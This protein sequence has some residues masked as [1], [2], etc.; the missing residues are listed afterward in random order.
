MNLVRSFSSVGL[1]TLA[2]RIFGFVRDMLMARYIGA[3]FAS[4]AFL[5]AFRLPNMFRALFAE[6][7]FAAAFVPLFNRKVGE[8]EGKL[9]EALRFAEDALSVLLPVLLVFTTVVMIGAGPAVL[10]MSGGF[11]D[12]TPEQFDYAVE[13]AR[14]TF[15]YLL[16][17][18]LVSLLGGIL[19]SIGRFWVNAAAPI[20]LNLTVIVALLL[21]NS[22]DPLQTARVEA[23][24]VTVSGV[25]QLLWL[26]FACRQ[27][28]IR[29][30]I[31]R[32]RLSP[33]VK[34][35]LSLIWP[36]AAGAGAVQINL[37]VSTALAAGFL[38]EGS[39]S[40]IYY[41][42]RLNQLPLGLIGIGLGTVL[43]PTI[44]RLISSGDEAGA[45]DMQRRGLQLAMFLT[46]PATVALMVSAEPIIRG[47]LQYGAFTAADTV[48][49]AMALTAF[50]AGLPA[51]ILIKVLTPAFHARSDMK[52][53]LRFAL[54]AI[55]VNL[56][57]NLILIWPL[58]H[59]GPP[60]ATAIASWVNVLL[61]YVS[62]MRRGHF[63]TDPKL[64][65]HLFRLLIAAV[66]MGAALIVIN[67]LVDP[68]MNRTFGWRVAGLT[69]LV[70]GGVIVY[71]IATFATRAFTGAELK[72][73][74]RRRRTPK[75]G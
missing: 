54:V 23:I 32:P 20:L 68:M 28:G 36:A 19:N 24:A 39:V 48:G 69:L 18:S 65:R 14:I 47:L 51:Y 16:F 67:P 5:V 58:E 61:L 49:S 26:V 13:L 33:D 73:L 63:S 22:P 42:D 41:A 75:E 46:L 57:G 62:L 15:P 56:V 45:L 55:A 27:A 43:L 44:T 10:L 3:S 25:L 2:S 52:T 6:G 37:V 53:P 21:F 70:G 74:L 1:L 17:I 38:P 30:K 60:L 59:V 35:L 40:Y 64:N 9:D 4:D 29:L 11:H 31:R 8:N 7:A 50:S 71:A 72:S 66:L 34:R 12:A